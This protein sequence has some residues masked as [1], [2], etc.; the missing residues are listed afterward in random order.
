MVSR[1]LG[2]ILL[3]SGL[4]V[5]ACRPM[6]E[7]GAAPLPALSPTP[8]PTTP[9]FLRTACLY[10]TTPADNVECGYLLVP[11]NRSQ[12]DSR[13]IRLHVLIFKSASEQSQPD[14]LILLN[15]GPG[16]P[17]QPMIDSMLHDRIGEIWRSERDVI[18]IDQRGTGFSMP[19]LYCPETAAAED[20]IAS[21]SY[22]EDIALEAQGIQQCYARLQREGMNLAAYN[23]VESAADINDL[24]I[25]LGYERVNLYGFS[26]G[27]LLA[28]TIMRQYPTTLRSVVL[29]AILPAGVDVA[30]EKPRCLQS[31]LNALFAGCT[32]DAICHAAYPALEAHLYAL[33]DRLHKAPATVVLHVLDDEHWVS[34]DDLKFLNYIFVQLQTGAIGP[35]PAQIE[36]AFAGDYTAPAWAWLNYAYRQQ[37]P[38]S[39]LTQSA[40]DGMYYSTMCNYTAGLDNQ[41]ALPCKSCAVA[42]QHPAL[43][44]Y[45]DFM[46]A[47]CAFWEAGAAPAIAT[48]PPTTSTVP[49]LLLTSAYDCALPPYLSQGLAATLAQSYQYVLPAG[50]AAALSPCGLYLTVQF[51]ADPTQAPDAACVNEM[52][53][54]WPVR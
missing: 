29:D 15:G 50:H 49:T 17:S 11:E 13:T 14:P 53:I 42:S 20:L 37:T 28:Q 39:R 8:Q 18:Y 22:E 6:I 38:A 5:S 30:G 16:S 51:L 3:V 24:R 26:Y 12:P 23:I 52:E 45:A 32:A 19:S 43:A 33:L 7:T 4:V 34:L 25:V 41:A 47:P 1:L 36:A 21:V 44:A 46:L 10:R 31:G 35:L 40:A 48:A 9:S 2:F 27:S 54:Y